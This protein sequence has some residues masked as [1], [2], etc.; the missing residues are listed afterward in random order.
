MPSFQEGRSV[1]PTDSTLVSA[2][3]PQS[4][5]S[6]YGSP[7]VTVLERSRF[8][9][10]GGTGI[11]FATDVDTL[12]KA[13]QAKQPELSQ[14]LQVKKEDEEKPVQKLRKRCK[15]N[16]PGCTK[17]F[18]SKAHLQIHVRSHTG[19][20]PFICRASSCGQRFSQLGNLKT[21]ERRHTGERPYSCDIC[22]KTFAQR[23]N[24]RAHKIVHQNT[25]PFPCRLDGCGK[26]FTQLGN[27]K[28]HQNKFHAANLRYLT[29]EVLNTSPDDWIS[30]QDK[31]LWE[32]FV[33][34]YK[35]SNKGIKGRGKG[36]R[37]FSA[38]IPHNDS[39]S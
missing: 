6:F 2:S 39:S 10:T 18:Q 5:T 15:C 3:L 36:T 28:S 9:P 19:A 32:H 8:E 20:K 31:E 25:K 33:S 24:V 17:G 23:G 29:Q 21:H 34:L 27:L 16:I 30:H 22:G 38:P 12:M 1:F 4:I 35:N 7:D 14:V 26:Q 11:D 13:I 37:V